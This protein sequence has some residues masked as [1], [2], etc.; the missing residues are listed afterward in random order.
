MRCYGSGTMQYQRTDVRSDFILLASSILIMKIAIVGGGPAGAYLGYCLAKEGIK[1]TIFDDSHPREKPC[2]GGLSSLA[3]KKFPFLRELNYNRNDEWLRLVSPTWK[4]ALVTGEEESMSVS[5]KRMDMFILKMAE[6]EGADLAEEG[7]LDF[8]RKCGGWRI[9]TK[10]KIYG[11]DFIVGADGVNSLV[12]KK[13]IGPIPPENLC[14]CAGCFAESP[15]HGEE[16]TTMRFLRGMEGYAWLFPRESDL[17]IGVGS[18]LKNGR[19]L[20]RELDDFMKRYAP[21]V[22]ITSRWAAMLPLPKDPAFLRMPASGS[23]WLLVGDA[24]GH[25][26]P[27]TGEGITYALWSGELAGRAIACGNAGSYERLWRKEYGGSIQDGIRM[28]RLL[29]HGVLLEVL[30]RLASRS[31]T[32]GSIM[33]DVIDSEQEFAA[34]RR[35]IARQLLFIFRELASRPSSQNLTRI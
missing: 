27:L 20:R 28:R 34:A 21:K 24:A 30:V 22:R 11:A 3:I 18:G 25:T 2:G 23:G 10:R 15:A 7:V 31:R 33:C 16:I 19:F 14:V 6:G 32:F 17:S 1:A 26:N 12:R 35:R 13:L 9:K 4:E 8:A 29:S 5:R